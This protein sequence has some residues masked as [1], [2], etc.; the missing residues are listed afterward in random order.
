MNSKNSLA[1]IDSAFKWGKT[2]NISILISVCGLPSNYGGYTSS[3]N[4]A[5]ILSA[6]DHILERYHDHPHFIG[7]EIISTFSKRQQYPSNLVHYYQQAYHIIR[8]HSLSIF[9]IIHETSRWWVGIWRQQL[10]EPIYYNVATDLRLS[11]SYKNLLSDNYS[12]FINDV[13]LWRARIQKESVLKPVIV[14]SWSFLPKDGDSSAVPLTMK[15][16]L[17][18]EQLL[19]MN[20]VLGS[21]VW[22]WKLSTHQNI[23]N[24][25]SVR[26]ELSRQDGL[27]YE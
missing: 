24:N 6:L 4:F 8:S 19:A 21:Y 1:H 17:I 2:Y 20:C 23:S 3:L 15:Q 22:T 13:Q 10:Q 14:G 27:H 5:L 25:N 18:H 26:D 11:L 12:D 7:I 16:R 9:I